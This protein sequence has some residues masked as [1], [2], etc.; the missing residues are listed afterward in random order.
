M[1][2]GN[3]AAMRLSMLVLLV[4]AFLGICFSRSVGV[5]QA[6]I[7]SCTTDA[8]HALRDQTTG[9]SI[10]PPNQISWQSA[11]WSLVPIA[12]NSMTQ[13]SS[14]VFGFPSKYSFALRSSPILYGFEALYTVVMFV[15]NAF[16]LKN[17]KASALKIAKWRFRYTPG[18][19]E[20]SLQK[21]QENTIFRIAIFLLG[22][23]PQIINSAVC[24]G[25]YGPRCGALCSWAPSS[26]WNFSS[27]CSGETGKPTTPT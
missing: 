18:N 9:V 20:G 12:L 5:A 24:K 3:T 16:F 7:E 19:E 13:P 17:P 26:S 27:S 11:F 10:S 25:Y 14:I 22:A 23:L 8:V 15:L 6:K 1:A 21:L 2:L 4:L